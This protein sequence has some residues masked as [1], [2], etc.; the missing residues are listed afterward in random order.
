MT[1]TLR[2]GSK[3]GFTLLE[4]MVTL[5]IM[6]LMSGVVIASIRPALEDA[7][8]RASACMVIAAL[9]YARGYAV[10]HRTDAAVTFDVERRGVSVQARAQNADG[11]ETWS[12]VTTQAGRFRSLPAGVEIV[13]ITRPDT[14]AVSDTMTTVT[15]STL[16]QAEDAGIILGDARGHQRII[17]VD[18]IT[19]RCELA[20]NTT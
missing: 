19:G 4:L 14:A 8:L 16:G 7:R 17:V 12:V 2:T 10:S 20:R 13:D 15:F 1:P 11:E 18:A 9:R 6:V 3:R 5:V